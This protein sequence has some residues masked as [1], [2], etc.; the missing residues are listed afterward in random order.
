[1]KNTAES[2]FGVENVFDAFRVTSQYIRRLI[3]C[4]RVPSRGMA[5]YIDNSCHI[6]QT[7]DGIDEVDILTT[8]TTI[9]DHQ[10]DGMTTSSLIDVS[11]GT[12]PVNIVFVYPAL[13]KCFIG[14]CEISPRALY[15]SS[16]TEDLHTKTP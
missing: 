4:A 6:D 5:D 9:Q 16:I 7:A 13:W 15:L 10:N 8:Y 2:L 1:M 14:R 3:L 11:V 12:A